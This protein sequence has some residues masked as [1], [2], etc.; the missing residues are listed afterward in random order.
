MEGEPIYL[1]PFLL[2]KAYAN[3]YNCYENLNYGNIRDFLS[4]LTGSPYSEW[5]L[6]QKKNKPDPSHSLTIITQHSTDG[7]IMLGYSEQKDTYLPLFLVKDSYTADSLF[8]YH[9]PTNNN[10]VATV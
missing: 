9:D 5:P 7:S 2:E 8:G 3:Y 6:T 1:W 10:E 4:E